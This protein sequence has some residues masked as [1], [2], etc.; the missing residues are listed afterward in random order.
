MN[1]IFQSL[2]VLLVFALSV[3]ASG[4]AIPMEKAERHP[5]V[6]SPVRVKIMED[7]KKA[8]EEKYSLWDLKEKRLGI[9]LSSHFDLCREREARIQNSDLNSFE[10]R[11]LMCLSHLRD[12]HVNMKGITSRPYLIVGL[13]L[14]RIGNQIVIAGYDP[15]VLKWAMGGKAREEKDFPWSAQFAP[16]TIVESID[17]IAPQHWVKILKS[18]ISGSSSEYVDAEAVK[19]LTLRDFFYP[20]RKTLRVKLA[21]LPEP[22]ELEW[23]AHPMVLREDLRQRLLVDL[24]LHTSFFL[25][26]D[27]FRSPDG[28]GYDYVGYDDRSSL[29][30][31]EVS[32]TSGKALETHFGSSPFPA[33]IN[34]A[35]EF[36]GKK[37]CYL[38]I[39]NS[40][41][42][43]LRK[44]QTAVTRFKREKIL[45]PIL[46]NCQA[47]FQGLI[48]D[49]RRN[50][51]GSYD[52]PIADAQ[53]LMPV[54]SS[55]PSAFTTGRRTDHLRRAYDVFNLGPEFPLSDWKDF[56]QD[57]FYRSIVQ[58]EVESLSHISAVPERNV[59]VPAGQSGFDLPMVVLTSPYCVSGCELMS[60]ILRNRPKTLF[61]GT[62]TNGTAGMI[63]TNRFLPLN[64]GWRDELYDTLQI[65]MPNTLFGVLPRAVET[66]ELIPFEQVEGQLLENSPLKPHLEH[67]VTLKDLNQGNQD[68]LSVIERAFGLLR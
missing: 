2:C 8:F 9:N 39:N 34:G 46:A 20:N 68:Y 22:I 44:K 40:V 10:D 4:S 64:S 62:P 57:R 61:V 38:K 29:I 5:K 30:P 26:F 49:L 59:Q 35:I 67:R 56:S 53:L 28:F 63:F 23:L 14:R 24:G 25:R 66:G 32:L 7:I 11:L 27:R 37:Y 41:E 31:E 16:G 33:L 19:A 60:S 17:G 13:S 54:G 50:P 58:A 45:T 42:S 3:S 55:F 1:F 52:V 18:F 65:R 43:E 47:N 48:L 36:S 51:G 6:S 15:K 12:S 21:S